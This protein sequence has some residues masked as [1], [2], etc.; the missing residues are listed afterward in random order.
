MFSSEY[1]SQQLV[2]TETV[3]RYIV[4]IYVKVAVFLIMQIC[5]SSDEHLTTLLARWFPGPSLFGVSKKR[6][7]CGSA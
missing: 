6:L 5:T 3:L 2:T 7:S 4:I 1:C